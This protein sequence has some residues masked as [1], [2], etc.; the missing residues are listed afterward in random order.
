MNTCKKCEGLDCWIDTCTGEKTNVI[1]LN[2]SW[3][4]PEIDLEKFS[5][6]SVIFLDFDNSVSPNTKVHIENKIN[7]QTFVSQNET[8]SVETFRL[9]LF[10]NSVRLVLIV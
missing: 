3:L 7:F 8:L 4:S 6:L 5:N 10:K 2:T 9:T 1:A